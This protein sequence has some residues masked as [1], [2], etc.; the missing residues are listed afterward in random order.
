MMDGTAPACRS[1]MPLGSFG[2][3][4]SQNRQILRGKSHADAEF[5]TLA[6]GSTVT[7]ASAQS[8]DLPNLFTMSSFGSIWM[9]TWPRN[10]HKYGLGITGDPPHNPRPRRFERLAAPPSHAAMATASTKSSWTPFAGR[11]M[12]RSRQA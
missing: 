2:P 10:L 1:W 8:G 11:Q 9:R 5:A 4:A 3:Q 7:T 6:P 12:S